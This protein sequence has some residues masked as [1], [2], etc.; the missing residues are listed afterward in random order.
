M[1]RQLM[2]CMCELYNSL[3]DVPLEQKLYIKGENLTKVKLY[4]TAYFYRM[5]DGAKFD[6]NTVPYQKIVADKITKEQTIQI[7]MEVANLPNMSVGNLIGLITQI[8]PVRYQNLKGTF[9]S[10]FTSSCGTPLI[11]ALENLQYLFLEMSSANYK[12]KITAYSLN[13]LVTKTAKQCISLLNGL[14]IKL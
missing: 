12:T 8:N 1:N 7:G 4:V 5:I 10:Y 11:F 2:T 3:W 14:D 6:P 9:I 13:R